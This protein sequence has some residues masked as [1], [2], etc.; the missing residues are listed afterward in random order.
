MKNE[1]FIYLDGNAIS[2]DGYFLSVNGISLDLIID[3]LPTDVNFEGART[4]GWSSNVG[5]SEKGYITLANGTPFVFGE[6]KYNDY[7][8]P[9]VN[10]W[11]A[12]KDEQDQQQQEAE[13][14]YN[15]F[16][17]RQARALVQ[18]NQDFETA[19]QRAH[20][21]SSLGF[22]VDANSTANEN[23]NG[24]LVTIG[25]GTVDFCD[26]YNQFHELNKSQLETLQSEIVQNGQSLYVQKWQYR[27][28]IEN[29]SNNEQL[30][31]VLETIEFT[32]MD[33][34]P[35]TDQGESQTE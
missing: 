4:I 29:C 34:T 32:Y 22:E 31:A 20:V 8:Q 9:Y 33:F 17:N 35:Q 11:Q 14:E 12:K 28:A 19:A 13:A 10:I 3:K 21:K 24:L 15:R 1:V 26:Y 25:S 2:V 18:L 16:E 30:D 6:D 27:T 23:V 7:I 5:L